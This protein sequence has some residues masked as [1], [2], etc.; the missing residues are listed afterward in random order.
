MLA[1]VAVVVLALALPDGRNVV[2]GPEFPSRDVCIQVVQ[3]LGYQKQHNNDKI[4]CVDMSTLSNKQKEDSKNLS[5][6]S[7]KE[8]DFVHP[9]TE[10]PDQD[11]L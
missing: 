4:Y 2:Y 11:K 5:P 10:M 1:F 3:H 8:E 6:E 7:L 9:L